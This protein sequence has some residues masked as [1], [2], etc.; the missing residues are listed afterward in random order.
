MFTNSLAFYSERLRI[1]LKTFPVL[2]SAK[3]TVAKLFD[4]SNGITSLNILRTFPLFAPYSEGSYGTKSKLT[5]QAI[6][7]IV[8]LLNTFARSVGNKRLELADIESIPQSPMDIEAATIL[9]ECLDR[10]GSDKAGHKY[11][12]FYGPILRQ[13]ESVSGVLEIGLGTNN[14]SVVS[15]MGARGR[16]GASL[17]ALRDFLPNAKLYG[18]DIDKTV[19]FKEAR[20]ETFFVDQTDPITLRGLDDMI[21]NDLDLIIDDGLHAVNANIATLTFGMPKVKIG[22]WV[23]IEDISF[24]AVPFWQVVAQLI[25]ESYEAHFFEAFGGTLFAVKRLS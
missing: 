1:H 8:P 5:I 13:R 16:P 14:I 20:I 2:V 25:P 24:T 22:G 6:N 15:N 17:R 9:K 10:H 19:L 4:R 11:H 21:P 12:Y 7:Q 18:A 23:V 3:R